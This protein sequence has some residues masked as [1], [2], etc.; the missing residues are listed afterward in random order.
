VV[1]E[2][3]TLLDDEK[4]S[5]AERRKNARAVERAD[6]P[7][8]VARSQR[9]IVVELHVDIPSAEQTR[10]RFKAWA[11]LKSGQESSKVYVERQ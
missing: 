7:A 4:R 9:P 2:W 3:K 10:K 1:S 11:I 5:A 6:K 8:R